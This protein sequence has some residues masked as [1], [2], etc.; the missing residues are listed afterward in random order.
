ML[1]QKTRYSKD[2]KGKFGKEC[3][4]F[5]IISSNAQVVRFGKDTEK[6]LFQLYNQNIRKLNHGAKECIYECAPEYLA[7]RIFNLCLI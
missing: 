5:L 7:Y 6:D 2:N 3:G 4:L 1:L